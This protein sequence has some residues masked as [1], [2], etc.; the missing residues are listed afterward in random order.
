MEKN[1]RGILI[2]LIVVLSI[3]ALLLTGILTFS[4]VSEMPSFSSIKLKTIYDEAYST[5]EISNISI[6]SDAGDVIVRNSTDGQIRLTAEG[7]NEKDFEAA[8]NGDTL[9]VSSRSAG[10]NKW[11]N[12]HSRR[13]IREIILYIPTDFNALDI[14][15]N[16][17]DVEIEDNLNTKLTVENNMGDIEAKTLAGSFNLHT[18]MG[19]IEINRIDISENSS[20]TTSM[21]DIEIENANGVN[22]YAKTSM[23]DCDVKNNTPSSPI[24]LTAE[25]DMG[26][27]EIND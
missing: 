19:N 15:L 25:T 13:G 21:G 24:I 12:L 26:N 5:S 2:T 7:T 16:L 10:R 11:L 1:N 20:A 18:D 4:I 9:T 8:V 14:N 22:I 3:I 23:G 27:V 6:D 17:G